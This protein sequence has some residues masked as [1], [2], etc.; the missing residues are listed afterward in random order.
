MPCKRRSVLR[1]AQGDTRDLT[2]GVR[3][4]HGRR[5]RQDPVGDRACGSEG[6]SR[7]RG[8][9]GNAPRHALHEGPARDSVG[10]IHALGHYLSLSKITPSERALNGFL[11]SF[12]KD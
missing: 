7:Y 1:E 8:D 10:C 6:D 12:T 4:V 11:D 2:V 3:G 9:D 5:E